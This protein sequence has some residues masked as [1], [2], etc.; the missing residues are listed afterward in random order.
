MLDHKK[1]IIVLSLVALS[2]S[3][4]SGAFAYWNFVAAPRQAMTIRIDGQPVDVESR[5]KT[6]SSVLGELSI[7]VNPGDIVKPGLKTAT[8]EG[9]QIDISTRKTICLDIDG[10]KT[11]IAT[12]HA[13]LSGFLAERNIQMGPD[14]ILEPEASMRVREGMTVRIR[15]AVFQEI[16]EKVAIDFKEVHRD[17]AGLLRGETKIAAQGSKGEIIKIFRVCLLDGKELRREMISEEVTK[18][19]ADRV[20]LVG[21]KPVTLAS[22]HQDTHNASPVTPEAPQERGAIA[23]KEQGIASYYTLNG[24]GIG[25]TAAHKSLPFGTVVKVTN[26]N[27]GKSVSVTINDRGPYVKGRVIDLATD[28]F[29]VIASTSQGVCPVALEW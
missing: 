4:F 3:V 2:L 26:L 22:R 19:P 21:I 11:R 24:K 13:R 5:S 20:I 28:A 23:P 27:N 25:M 14:D 16:V 17:D 18:R 29:K 15:H 12:N 6:V 1:C 9:M 10:R 8:S 7:R